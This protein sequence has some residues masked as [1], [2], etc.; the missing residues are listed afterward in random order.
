MTS[1]QQ[2][3]MGVPHKIQQTGGTDQPLLDLGIPYAR[4]DGIAVQDAA[5]N[6]KAAL[7]ECGIFVA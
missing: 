4:G 2:G 3:E 1:E 6:M 7:K 5:E